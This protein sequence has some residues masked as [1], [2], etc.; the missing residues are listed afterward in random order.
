MF[1]DYYT[2]K[3]SGLCEVDVIYYLLLLPRFP[4]HPSSCVYDDDTD[5]T[6][7]ITEVIK[8]KAT[9]RWILHILESPEHV[10]SITLFGSHKLCLD[11][12]NTICELIPVC[13]TINDL[14]SLQNKWSVWQTAKNFTPMARFIQM[15]HKGY[16]DAL[17][18]LIAIYTN[19]SEKCSTDTNRLWYMHEQYINAIRKE[20]SK[21][22]PAIY[23]KEYN[24]G[25]TRALEGLSMFQLT[26]VLGPLGPTDAL[27]PAGDT[28]FRAND[29]MR[30]RAKFAHTVGWYSSISTEL[31]I[32]SENLEMHKRD[33]TAVCSGAPTDVDRF[34]HSIEAG[35]LLNILETRVLRSHSGSQFNIHERKT[36]IHQKF[37][38][39]FVSHLHSSKYHT[40]ALMIQ[41]SYDVY[42]SGMYMHDATYDNSKKYVDTLFT[43]IN[44]QMNS[45]TSRVLN[46]TV[47]NLTNNCTSYQ[48]TGCHKPAPLL[49]INHKYRRVYALLCLSYRNL[50]V[51]IHNEPMRTVKQAKSHIRHYFIAFLYNY[52]NETSTIQPYKIVTLDFTDIGRI[53]GNGNWVYFTT[54]VEKVKADI[55]QQHTYLKPALYTPII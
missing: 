51:W 26:Q 11:V 32:Y 24:F 16:P 28:R 20:F 7:M 46:C 21:L 41:K 25:L 38:S 45:I 42:T 3:A 22:E 4:N 12:F 55:K 33:T 44:Q 6:N 14:L 31:Q 13:L 23:E 36:D 29:I 37:I 54:F 43:Q 18:G 2:L 1:A 27:D 47:D 8:K 5:I 39:R 53:L 17:R 52:L 10:H 34:N 49:S 40:L 15:A 9:K 48:S 50:G 30:A 19:Y 35:P